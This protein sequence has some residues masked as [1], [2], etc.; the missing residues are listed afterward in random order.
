ISL[1]HNTNFSFSCLPKSNRH[2]IEWITVYKVSSSIDRIN[3][4]GPFFGKIFIILRFF[5][6]KIIFWKS[7]T[8]TI[9]N[10]ALGIYISLSNK[11]IL[12]FKAD[13]K[14]ALFLIFL[15]QICGFTGA[16][17]SNF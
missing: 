13:I 4:P 11:V 16:L 2:T 17:F 12:P 9:H 8:Y 6:Y 1:Q 14:R 5:S 10:N 3:N 15:N 7:L